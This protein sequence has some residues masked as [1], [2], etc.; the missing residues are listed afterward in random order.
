MAM[1]KTGG[2]EKIEVLRGKE[3]VVL[4]EHLA[5]TGKSLEDFTKKEREEL[6]ADLDEV[7]EEAD[8]E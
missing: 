7:R 1:R 5:K 2:P 8:D 3:A 6:H 4:N